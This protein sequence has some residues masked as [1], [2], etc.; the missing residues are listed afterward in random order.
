M[1]ALALTLHQADG[2]I[3]HISARPRRLAVERLLEGRSP[4]A[5]L[6]QAGL[7]FALCPAAQSQALALALQAAGAAVPLPA[8]DTVLAERCLSHVRRLAMLPPADAGL[9]RTAMAAAAAGDWPGLATALRAAAL[10]AAALAE[11]WA[12]TR[13]PPA[14]AL[15][16]LD[17]ASALA[18]L[19]GDAGVQQFPTLGGCA[20][21]ASPIAGTSP[22]QRL[23]GA[24]R[25]L[26]GLAAAVI[27]KAGRRQM[28]LQ[29]QSI[30]GGAGQGAAVVA[31]AR[32]P[33]AVAVWLA[34][35]RL[36][37]YRS[38]APTEW[39]F[40][41]DGVLARALCG[42]PATPATLA[43][44]RQW[45]LALDACVPVTVEM[46]IAAVPQ[47]ELAHA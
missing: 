36:C 28:A 15:G 24:A 16:D 33:L 5:A 4:A 44:A 38:I 2:L 19:A 9:A 43:L 45:T 41:P 25:L 14:P 21:D 23:Q 3:S 13:S 26:D 11:G 35:G 12:D 31:T 42:R 1:T 32:G 20:R 29:G 7:V 27:S 40:H 18:M 6:Q 39:T 47:Q 22:R 46:A 34:D 10:R 8:A 17:A 30:W 37:R